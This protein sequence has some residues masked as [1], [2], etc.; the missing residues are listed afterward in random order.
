MIQVMK[1]SRRRFLQL[2]SSA[3]AATALTM[4]GVRAEA[5]STP[6]AKAILYD[7]SRCTGCRV[8]EVA[9]QKWNRLP[10]RESQYAGHYED[11]REVAAYKWLSIRQETSRPKPAVERSFAR[12]SCMHCAEAACL[13]V[14]PAGAIRRTEFGAVVIDQKRC[15]GCSYCIANCPYQVI[16]FDR[17]S[18]T[19]RRCTFCNDRVSDNLPP[20]CVHACPARALDF[21]DR[22]D[23]VVRAR[24][25]VDELRTQ[26]PYAD[27]Y[28]PGELK[29]LG[30]LHVLPHGREHF[31]AAHGLPDSPQ[32]PGRVQVWD[33][34]FQPLRVVLGAGIAVGLLLNWRWSS[35][36][37]KPHKS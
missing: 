23:V 10:L 32:I 11:R 6:R 36:L 1:V 13:M 35:Q 24:R 27:V 19:A 34:L 28:G 22:D 21:G 7:S 29:G 4:T 5:Q 3:V 31:A 17:V 26:F 16:G 8:C 2:C 15:I 18:S 25:R 12:V 14:C 9:C 33:T 37:N 30:V 20:A